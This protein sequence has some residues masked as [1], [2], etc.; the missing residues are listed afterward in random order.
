MARSEEKG[1]KGVIRKKSRKKKKKIMKMHSLCKD[2]RVAMHSFMPENW[3]KRTRYEIQNTNYI[4]LGS[5]TR[6]SKLSFYVG[7]WEIGEIVDYKILLIFWF[8]I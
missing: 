8:K 5:S 2:S 7:S 1:Q 4:G 6:L 3:K